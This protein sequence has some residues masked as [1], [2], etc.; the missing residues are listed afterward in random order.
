MVTKQLEIWINEDD[1]S[2]FDGHVV[3][4]FEFEILECLA[5]N[6]FEIDVFPDHIFEQLRKAE[7][8]ST[9]V[10]AL[11]H[12]FCDFCQHQCICFDSSSW[13]CSVDETI[14][15]VTGYFLLL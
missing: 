14:V 10:E 4:E 5:C 13:S 12:P 15:L 2:S 1:C 9:P 8:E 7:G 3:F 6:H 11:F